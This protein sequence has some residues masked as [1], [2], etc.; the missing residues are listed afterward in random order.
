MR[1]RENAY[2]GILYTVCT[3]AISNLPCLRV[4][5]VQYVR[6]FDTASGKQLKRTRQFLGSALKFSLISRLKLAMLFLKT[7]MPLMSQTSE[8]TI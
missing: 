8:V 6:S 3:T 1:V 2:S 4:G 7:T 5:S